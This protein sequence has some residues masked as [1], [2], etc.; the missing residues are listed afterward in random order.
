MIISEKQIMQL[1]KIAYDHLHIISLDIHD[2]DNA[3]S[4]Y[5]SLS[6]FL[7]DISSQQSNELKEIK[8]D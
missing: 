7:M 5:S 3:R 8:N 1:I 6:S 2:D 4:C